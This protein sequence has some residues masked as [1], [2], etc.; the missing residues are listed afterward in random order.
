MKNKLI[1]AND[2]V[3]YNFDDLLGVNIKTLEIYNY[4]L[5]EI[6]LEIFKKSE[7]SITKLI[8]DNCEF[9]ETIKLSKMTN[10]ECTNIIVS[11]NELIKQFN[12]T[13]TILKQFEIET[14][15]NITELTNRRTQFMNQIIYNKIVKLI[16]KLK[17][18]KILHLTNNNIM[19]APSFIFKMSY[20]EE[21]DLSNNNIYYFVYCGK[22]KKQIKQLNI[23]I[24][25]KKL[26][27]NNNKISSI[28]YDIRNMKYLQELKINTLNNNIKLN[29]N[30]DLNNFVKN[31]II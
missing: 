15:I 20:L 24:N 18:L 5:N 31:S 10:K 7:K 22:N 27:L 26:N 4:L 14:S 2:V 3:Y 29:E 6:P 8:F 28:P 25:L 19:F 16:S 1:K 12:I 30:L 9:K 17:N 23:L 21:L 13:N 11:I